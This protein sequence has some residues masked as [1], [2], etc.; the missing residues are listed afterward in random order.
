MSLR[1]LVALVA[2]STA[3]FAAGQRTLVLWGIPSDDHGLQAC[4][5]AFEDRHPN[6][7][8]KALNMGAG[9]LN[10]QKLMTGIVGRVPPDVIYQ[11][12]FSVSDWAARGA[13]QPLDSDI[14]R[15][16]LARPDFV[17]AA[18]DEAS[19]EGRQYG[20]PYHVDV[21]V[22]FWNRE[23]F[24]REAATLR[25]VGLDPD[26]PPSTWKSLLAYS[27]ALTR[28]APDGRIA[29]LGFAP[30][31]GNAW[32]YLYALTS[33]GSF[34]SSDGR[35]C[36][37][38]TAP[39]ERA[40][41]FMKDGYDLAGG[42]QKVNE[43]LASSPGEDPF[44]A[45]RIAMKIDGDW[46]LNDL[47]RKFPNLDFAVA[48]PPSQEDSSNGPATWSGGT[49][50]CIPTGA[51]NLGD[52]WQFIRFVTS[53]EG[54]K[55]ASEEQSAWARADGHGYAPARPA[56]LEADQAAMHLYRT[57][58]AVRFWDAEK[59]VGKL[60]PLSQARPPSVAEQSLW[61]A[62]AHA[63]DLA[64]L[65]RE[66]P[67]L[68]LAK[69][70]KTVQR[71]L[72]EVYRQGD[73][74]EVRFGPW[75]WIAP[76]LLV[77]LLVVVWW[78]A[79]RRLRPAARRDAIA[80]S[81]FVS[82]WL[83]GFAVLTL[84]PVLASLAYSFMQ[85]NVLSPPRWVGLANYR[86]MVGDDAADVGHA[87]S[88][89]LWLAGFGVPL[90]VVTGLSVALMLR[91]S[92]RGVALWR[93]VF[94]MPSLVPA[95][96]AAVLWAW[97]LAP[98]PGVG[99]VNTIWE[100]SLDHWFHWAPPGWL[101]APEWSKPALILMGLWGAGSGML[102]WLAG[103]NGI[104]SV[105]YEAATLDGAGPRRR[106][107]SITFPQLSPVIFFNLVVGFIGG[108]QEFDRAYV[109]TAG[110]SF[111]TG[112]SLLTPVYYLFANGF[113]YF[114]MGYASALAWSVFA[115]IFLLTIAQFGLARLWVYYEGDRA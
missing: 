75:V 83:F 112:D 89:A 67:A 95:V 41:A 113:G 56:Q 37:L 43:F 54:W 58:A 82:P 110:G 103:L 35:T 53:P 61:D 62:Q 91:G 92:S 1:W 88:N 26:R 47:A 51:R 4:I 33:G 9:G 111:G 66:S 94:Y 98:T 114:R 69:A 60:L 48:P 107:W 46:I 3:A 100:I 36:T 102:L 93:A 13:F 17:P 50:F 15:D 87:F 101:S 63:I 104:P 44:A 29:Q 71:A 86:L 108:I 52:A 84:G 57:D 12:R 40:L 34:F 74:P 18:W 23:L 7:R 79:V 8:V 16:H 6:I 115:L 25:A 28:Y 59:E 105:L 81:L 55:L 11:D 19:Y 39:T 45:G 76:V 14:A 77:L 73:Y 38:D 99:I 68:A 80:G 24:H 65:G 109:V 49:C 96:V 10:P 31:Y 72:D 97:L 90:G 22:L 20:I 5:Q 78:R 42:Y 64:C 30:N 21:R 32:L 85:W 2:V 106:F 70:Q 27:R